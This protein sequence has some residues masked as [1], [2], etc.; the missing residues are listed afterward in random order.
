MS[1]AEMNVVPLGQPESATTMKHDNWRRATYG[2]IASVFLRLSVLG[3][4]GPNAHIAM[5]LDEVVERR[6]W[7]TREHF[8]QLVALTNLL[9]GPNSSEV[10]I[11]I[12]YTQRGVRG[13][14]LAGGVFV[15]PTFLM[16]LLLS[17]LYFSAGEVPAMEALFGVLK[18]AMVAVILAAGWKLGRTAVTDIPLL[19]M[20]LCGAAVSIWL[21]GFEV[22]AMALGG[23]AGWMLYRTGS[24]KSAGDSSAPPP[25]PSKPGPASRL[26]TLLLPAGTTAFLTGEVARVFGLMLWSGAVLFGGGYMLVALLE[27]YAVGEFGWLTQQQFLDGVA[28][29]QALPGPIVTLAAF[30]GFAAAGTVGAVVATVGI[31]IPSF[32]AVFGVAPFLERWRQVGAV[33]AVLKGVTAVVS[34]AIIGV[35]LTLIAAAVPGAVT[36]VIL[37]AALAAA[38]AGVPVIRIVLVALAIGVL[39]HFTGLSL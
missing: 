20:A 37:L 12:G 29:T 14:V 7:V 17:H 19:L 32:A 18:P 34:G 27:P 1:A 35:A 5:M 3:F 8:L 36:G 16:V 39:A 10:A 22:A 4:G 31:Y 33:R 6:R 38:I 23:V 11:H 30:V 24:P 9:P 25:A 15:A 21:D 28:I 2:E 26:T 13:G